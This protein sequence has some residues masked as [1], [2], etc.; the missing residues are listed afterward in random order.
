MIILKAKD[1][2]AEIIILN[3]KANELKTASGIS[4]E[5]VINNG[6]GRETLFRGACAPRPFRLR[7]TSRKWSFALA[8]KI[9]ASPRRPGPTVLL[10]SIGARWCKPPPLHLQKHQPGP[11][12]TGSTALVIPQQRAAP[13]FSV[14]PQPLG[15]PGAGA[16]RDYVPT[17][18]RSPAANGLSPQ[19]PAGGLG[20]GVPKD[21][22]GAYKR[23]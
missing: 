12:G 7:Q 6:T 15:R 11:S 17:L 13:C 2:A 19:P 18:A 3:S 9:K 14:T 5:H 10:S 20:V 16:A 22:V 23:K 1:S 21:S 8:Q 4:S